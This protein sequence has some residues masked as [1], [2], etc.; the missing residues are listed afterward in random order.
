MAKKA[1]PAD[2]AAA[3]ALF[4]AFAFVSTP[5]RSN[6]EWLAHYVI[7]PGRVVSFDGQN[8]LSAPLPLDITACPQMDTFDRALGAARKTGAVVSFSV[9]ERLTI[10]AGRFRASVPM[11][12]HPDRIAAQEPEGVGAPCAPG[13]ADLCRK[14]APLTSTYTD[15][16][17]AWTGALWITPHGSALATETH[18]LIE[19]PSPLRVGQAIGIPRVSAARIGAIGVDPVGVQVAR[20]SA[21]FWYG[22][23]RYL[24]TPLV[25]CDF[26]A[27]QVA[28][29]YAAAGT[30]AQPVPDG[31]FDALATVAPFA[32]PALPAIVLDGSTVA[33][34]PRAEDA[35]TVDVP[36]M[37]VARCSFN[38]QQLLALREFANAID[39]GRWPQPC[40]WQGE[41]ARGVIIGCTL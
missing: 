31:F 5:V 25:D 11:F 30:H 21:T 14:L 15:G 36:G 37:S 33:S 13:F 29:I 27:A 38:A 26:P 10:S 16:A 8:T 20:K 7:T 2:D 18:V 17:R 1:K 24:R 28:R 41:Q 35:T 4:D 23:G 32:N 39:F 22:D 34:G 12:A 40:Y 19:V 9:A 3:A 6:L